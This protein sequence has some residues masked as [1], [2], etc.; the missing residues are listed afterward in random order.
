[1]NLSIDAISDLVN[2]RICSSLEQLVFDYGKIKQRISELD[3]QDKNT[4]PLNLQLK[5]IEDQYNLNYYFPFNFSSIDFLLAERKNR[6]DTMDKLERKE[7]LTE[8]ERSIHTSTLARIK[9]FNELIH[10]KSKTDFLKGIDY[11]TNHPDKIV[12]L[13][14]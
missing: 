3:N 1:M 11:Y 7:T 14:S 10:L 8:T 5:F 4:E 2:S 9:Y 12:N 6:F 13:I